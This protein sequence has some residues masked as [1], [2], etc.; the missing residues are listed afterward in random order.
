MNFVKK[1]IQTLLLTAVLICLSGCSGKD[2]PASSSGNIVCKD[3]EAWIKDG[4][5][6]G[7]IFVSDYDLIGVEVEAGENGE[8]WNGRKVGTYSASGDKLTLVFQDR[9]GDVIETDTMTYKVSGGKL[10]LSGGKETVVFT[11]RTGVHID[12]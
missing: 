4:E 12:L 3:G 2:N 9:K 1:S 11:K 5:D 10:T 6:V 7:Y 8:R